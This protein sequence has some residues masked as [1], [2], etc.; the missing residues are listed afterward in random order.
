MVDYRTLSRRKIEMTKLLDQFRKL[1]RSEYN[2]W[3][4]DDKLAFWINSLQS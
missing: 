1:D 3:S 2:S 4:N